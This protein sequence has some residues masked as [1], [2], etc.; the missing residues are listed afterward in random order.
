VVCPNAFADGI[1]SYFDGW[2]LI[3][4]SKDEALRLATNGLPIDPG[5]YILSYNEHYDGWRVQNALEAEGIT[6]HRIAF[7]NHNEDG[8]SLRCATHPLVRRLNSTA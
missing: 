4:V 7:D 8:G 1:P 2:K 3:E 5:H 6:V